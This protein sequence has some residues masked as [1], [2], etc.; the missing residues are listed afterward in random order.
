[1]SYDDA[2][3]GLIKYAVALYYRGAKDVAHGLES[4]EDVAAK[5]KRVVDEAMSAV[6]LP[7]LGCYAPL[8]SK[9]DV[10]KVKDNVVNCSLWRSKDK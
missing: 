1:M 2:R 3:D 10:D 4:C 8:L 7:C 6:V 5:V 9:A